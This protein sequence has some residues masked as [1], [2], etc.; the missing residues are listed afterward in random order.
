MFVL[1]ETDLLTTAL[2]TLV[3]FTFSLLTFAAETTEIGITHLHQQRISLQPQP[4]E[5]R[6]RAIVG[7]RASHSR[8][9]TSEVYINHD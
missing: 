9:K 6:H 1:L 5:L 8:S 3:C 4:S 2:G 7:P